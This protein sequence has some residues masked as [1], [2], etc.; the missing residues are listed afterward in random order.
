MTR[1][2]VKVIAAGAAILLTT[3]PARADDPES[4]FPTD[5]GLA[6]PL[7]ATGNNMV[8]S[9]FGWGETTVF[10][11]TL[12][13]FTTEQLVANQSCFGWSV[14]GSCLANNQIVGENIATKSYGAQANPFLGSPTTSNFAWTAGTEVVFGLMVQQAI[15]N[16]DLSQGFGYNWFF[17]GDPLRNSATDGFAHLAFF[18]TGGVP[19]D[20]GIG[21]IPGTEG[22]FLFGFED[23]AYEFSDW[24]FDNAIFQVDFN[25]INPPTDVV[26]E[27]T[28]MTLLA[29]GL[30][31]LAAAG[32]RRRK[33]APPA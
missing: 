27:P 16:Q 1:L 30:I 32:R 25:S 17:S 22:K 24:D 14:T 19:G 12:W 20:D 23:V 11:H 29:T 7:V 2:S 33:S 6:T 13:A 31:S 15:N 10:G 18:G 21:I 3:T 8:V 5:F 4:G 28:T 26:P 9:Y